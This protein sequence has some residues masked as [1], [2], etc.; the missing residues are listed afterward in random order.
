MGNGV[1]G[2]L[3]GVEG[4]TDGTKTEVGGGERTLSR[5]QSWKLP[6]RYISFGEDQAGVFGVFGRSVREDRVAGSRVVCDVEPLSFSDR[7]ATGELGR[8]DALVAEYIFD[9][10]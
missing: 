9:A 1:D 5:D 6:D 3:G 10:F 7:N 2:R 8:R 4:R